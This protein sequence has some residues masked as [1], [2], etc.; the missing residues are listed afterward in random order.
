MHRFKHLLLLLFFLFLSLHVS[1]QIDTTYIRRYRYTTL[2]RPYADLASFSFFVSP[3]EEQGEND[4]RTSKYEPNTRAALGLG[5]SL[6]KISIAAGIRLPRSKKREEIYG[7]TRY[8]DLRLRLMRDRLV[9]E[10]VYNK[11]TGFADLNSSAYS[12][13]VTE[14]KPYL[15]RGDLSFKMW[16]AK[17]IY[18][19][20][21]KKFSYRAAFNFTERQLKSAGSLLAV[22]DFHYNKA[23]SDSSFIP[24]QNE[25]S[26]GEFG[27]LRKLKLTG[28]GIGVG[29][30]YT[31]VKSKFFINGTILAGPDL[32]W[33]RLSNENNS[34]ERRD[35]RIAP[36]VDL[37][38]AMGVN[39][40][41]Y[42]LALT[43]VNNYN[44][45]WMPDLRARLERLILTLHVGMKIKSPRIIR[46][47]QE[48]EIYKKL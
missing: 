12:D 11:F 46:R 26:F 47:I 3:R 37:R 7:R 29:G 17:M 21:W 44:F 41:Q 34:D 14:E 19:F 48:K 2:I 45:I 16:R 35:R 42:L 40:D 33:S 20:S 24:F 25:A 15:L 30:T 13:D 32:Q 6:D 43:A 38:L 31:L 5:L 27:N 28:A 8:T 36:F 4:K 9:F 23:E 1:A 10:G 39:G 18:I 22:A